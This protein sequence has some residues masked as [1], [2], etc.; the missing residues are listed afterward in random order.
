MNFLKLSLVLLTFV[1]VSKT[2]FGQ[3]EER[4]ANYHF[5]SQSYAVALNL[6]KEL[7]EQD[8]LNAT[9]N[10]RLGLCYLN[11]NQ[12]P[13]SALQYL[14]TVDSLYAQ[15]VNFAYELGKAYLYN[16]QIEKSLS[17]FE[18]ALNL[19]VKDEDFRNLV[20]QW[21]IQAKNAQKLIQNPLDISFINLG[22]KLNSE[23]DELTPI[24]SPDGE[25]LFYTSNQQ[26]DQKFMLYTNNVY[27]ADV[28]DGI[29]EK[30]KKLST[31]SSI[32]DDF[33]A[34]FSLANDKLFVQMA[35]YEAFQDIMYAERIGK[36]FRGKNMLNENVN[37]KAGEFAVA[38]T[39][40]ADT[41]Y[42]S[43]NRE[44]GMG[45][46]DI[47]YSLKLP[48]GEWGEARNCGKTIN[49]PF[50]EDFPVLSNDGSVLFFCSDGDKSMGGFDIFSAKINEQTRDFSQVKNLGYP[51]NDV[52]DNKTIAFSP[53]QR[54]AYVSALRPGGMGYADIYRV[55]FNQED[56]SVKI[57]II[58]LMT[59]TDAEKTDLTIPD[60]TI[61]I[62]AFAKAKLVFGK[63]AYDFKSK[64]ATIA[65]P[66]GNYNLEING[67]SIEPAEYK[68]SVPDV[69][70]GAK[71]EKKVW[72]VKEKK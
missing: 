61:H 4:D 20:N 50:N 68:I 13:W 26:Y 49:T 37:S 17:A 72:L 53:N 71:I 3:K 33:V 64:Q 10:Y 70:S 59:G 16:L 28:D 40:N 54:Y 22:D 38:E 62:T 12:E 19:E 46:S 7:H 9:Y 52:F 47:Y 56:P 65:L 57:F 2:S 8:T 27:Y 67:A 15:D 29:F 31:V 21:I 1:F 39:V 43:S 25:L 45:G 5:K 14:L 60:S 34:G 41:L 11:T 35:G 42:F 63:Y 66:P 32:D 48:T 18:K 6:Y 23:M 36:S 58:S 44:G 51:L 30:G 69:P 55:V 24:I